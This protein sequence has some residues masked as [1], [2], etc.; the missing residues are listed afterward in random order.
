M[1]LKEVHCDDVKWTELEHDCLKFQY[2]LEV[3]F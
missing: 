3:N 2:K 1:Y